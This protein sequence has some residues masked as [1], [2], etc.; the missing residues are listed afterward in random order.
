MQLAVAGSVACHEFADMLDR[1][2]ITLPQAKHAAARS[3]LVWALLAELYLCLRE[4][5]LLRSTLVCSL[6]AC[7]QLLSANLCCAQ[8]C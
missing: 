8:H 1:A 3:D 5:V 7:I 2:C 6:T 4:G